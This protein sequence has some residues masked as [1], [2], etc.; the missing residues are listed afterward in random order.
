MDDDR[1]T[2]QAIAALGEGMESILKSDAFETGLT[3]A[4]ARIFE[5]WASSAD[6]EERENLH[7]EMRALERLLGAFKTLD[8]EGVVAREAIRQMQESDTDL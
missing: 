1:Q 2:L 7:A 4:R 6:P 8:D 5:G 3:L